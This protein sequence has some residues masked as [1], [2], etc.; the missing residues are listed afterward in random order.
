MA[1]ETVDV[2]GEP[3]NEEELDPRV[4]AALELARIVRTAVHREDD[5]EGHSFMDDEIVGQR[6][7][8]V[9]GGGC[10]TA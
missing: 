5:I 4:R 1:E 2:G 10:N 8:S 3:I 9:N 7:F 6:S